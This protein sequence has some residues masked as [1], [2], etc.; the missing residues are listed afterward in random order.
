M[1]CENVKFSNKINEW[2]ERMICDRIKEIDACS[3]KQ[4]IKY[5]QTGE[6]DLNCNKNID[7]SKYRGRFI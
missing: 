6:I 5:N 7:C 3:A 1:N 2:I 4:Y